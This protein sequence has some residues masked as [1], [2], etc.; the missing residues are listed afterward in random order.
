MAYGTATPMSQMNARLNQDATVRSQ[1][2]LELIID[3]SA[4]VAARSEEALKRTQ[5]VLSPLEVSN[6]SLAEGYACPP[7]RILA[8]PFDS[9]RSNLRRI[10]SMTE[11][12]ESLLKRLDI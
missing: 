3:L 4:D 6:T 9:I 2:G 8:V 12:L 1:S 7:D 5:Q 11:A 10:Q